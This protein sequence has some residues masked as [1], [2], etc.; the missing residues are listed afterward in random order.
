MLHSAYRELGGEEVSASVEAKL[1]EKAGHIVEFVEL[2]E[3]RQGSAAAAGL[4]IFSG[5]KS[6]ALISSFAPDVVHVQNFFPLV[7]PSVIKTANQAGAATVQTL[8]NYR[9]A[10]LG[11]TQY[12]DGKSCTDCSGT[13]FGAPAIRHG[14]YRGSRPTSLIGQVA[15]SRYSRHDTWT[16]DI[17]AFIAVSPHVRA[18]VASE[19][20]LERI[21]IKPNTTQAMNLPGDGSGGYAI[22]V[23][24]LIEEKG[25][26]LLAEAWS[27]HPDLPVLRLIGDGADRASIQ[28]IADEHENVELQVGPVAHD[29]IMRQLG[30]A[31]L[32]I[33]PSVWREPFGRVLVESFASG[34]PVL[35][36]DVDGVDPPGGKG[37]HLDT[38]H[39]RDPDTLVAATRSMLAK[40][41]PD[42]RRRARQ[43][44]DEQFSPE[45]NLL[46]LERIYQI[47]I[48][49]RSRL[50]AE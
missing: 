2:N 36:N 1:L 32:T 23:G 18:A 29:E 24:R 17:D 50:A 22:A 40:S 47:A 8:R 16:K 37:I 30:D 41:Q 44:F 33:I 28:A 21:E 38:F 27:R 46:E 7:P 45:R 14:C 13:R 34:T 5:S 31:C 3:L 11:G 15:L 39:L 48:D 6:R 4:Q 20:P 26:R 25:M 42:V 9:V 19:I 49:R 10:C 12:R 43:V 35:W